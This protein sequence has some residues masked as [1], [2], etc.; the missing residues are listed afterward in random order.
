MKV[1]LLREI[2]MMVGSFTVTDGITTLVTCLKH[3]FETLCLLVVS[4]AKLYVY[5]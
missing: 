2:I 4:I 1:T 3:Q 5:W